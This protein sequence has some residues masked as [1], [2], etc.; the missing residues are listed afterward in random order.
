[1]TF[2]VWRAIETGTDY[3]EDGLC[4]IADGAQT[5]PVTNGVPRF[6]SG[7]AYTSSFGL[8]WNKFQCTQLDSFSQVPLSRDRLRR[9]LGESAWKRLATSVVLECGCGAGRFTEV[10]LNEGASV[11][12][13]DLSTAVDANARNFPV[14]DS[15]RIA[16][17]DILALP[18][19]PKS[20]DLVI[21]LGVIQ[22][23]P[24]P[25]ATI[26]ALWAHVSDGGTL[27]IDHYE[28]GHSG[29]FHSTKPLV[30][31]LLKGREPVQAMRVTNRLVDLFFPIHVAVQ[32]AYPLWFL[33]CRLSPITTYLRM[34]P[35]LN[36]VAQREW[37][38]LDTHD[39]LTDY[40]K[41]ERTR[42][43]IH[44]VL[45]A[46]GGQQIWCVD[47]GNGVEARAVKPSASEEDRAIRPSDQG[48]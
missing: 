4:L 38:Y 27:V 36:P 21:C 42:E 37:A 5:V 7:E 30:R 24:D 8:Q 28:K 17:A 14:T 26:A 31:A 44:S 20:F 10:L 29:W 25:E 32:H 16:Q 23:T 33:L 18:F 12:S 22:H 11:M 41:H 39:S 2:P 43:Q 35:E 3:L 13:V 19:A 6:V 45:T 40:F 46:L 34:Y 1:M 15:H 47:G 9:C 48:G